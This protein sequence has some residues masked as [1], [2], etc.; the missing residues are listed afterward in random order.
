MSNRSRVR[1][2]TRDVHESDHLPKCQVA[3]GW[4]I[5]E[6]GVYGQAKNYQNAHRQ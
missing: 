5:E 3:G 6:P 1:N 2:D 4:E